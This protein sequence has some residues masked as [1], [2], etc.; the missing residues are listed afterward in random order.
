MDKSKKIELDPETIEFCQQYPDSTRAAVVRL[1]LAQRRLKAV[2][3][4]EFEGT[5]LYRFMRWYLK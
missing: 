5:I 2:I 3:L 1:H 4:K